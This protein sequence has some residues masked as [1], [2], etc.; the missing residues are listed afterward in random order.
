MQMVLSIQRD[1]RFSH[2][3]VQGQINREGFLTTIW[4]W[5]WWNLFNSGENDHPLIPPQ[6]RGNRGLATYSAR[7]EDDLPPW[8]PRGGNL[9]GTVKRLYCN[10]PR[11]SSLSWYKKFDD[12]IQSVGF[13]KSDEDH[14]IFIKK[15][16]RWIS[17]LPHLIHCR[18]VSRACVTRMEP[19]RPW[20]GEI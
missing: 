6:H 18:E 11:A 10:R 5:I 2:P 14:Y 17:H 8:W 9:H 20:T 16:S 4:R 13:S 3:K 7:C 19:S 15:G 1:V 12:F